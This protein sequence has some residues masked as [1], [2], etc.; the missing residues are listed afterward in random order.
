MAYLKLKV[1]FP[2][3]IMES[4]GLLNLGRFSV[5][6][7]ALSSWWSI[8]AEKLYV[9]GIM[10]LVAYMAKDVNRAMRQNIFGMTFHLLSLS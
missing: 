7:L 9:Y 10:Y 3:S 6:E 1:S 4:R 5:E 8:L 2:A